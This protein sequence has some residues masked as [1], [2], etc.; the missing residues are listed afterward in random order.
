M[1][2]F[3]TMTKEY[4]SDNEVFADAFN[5]LMYDGQQIIRPENLQELDTTELALPYGTDDAD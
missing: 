5:F 2:K 4:L 3:D 1:G